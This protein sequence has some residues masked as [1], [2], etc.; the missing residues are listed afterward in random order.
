MHLLSFEPLPGLWHLPTQFEAR[1]SHIG[2]FNPA[3]AGESTPT[4]PIR[5]IAKKTS[6]GIFEPPEVE[7]PNL[8]TRLNLLFSDQGLGEGLLLP[9]EARR[10]S[11]SDACTA[12]QKGPASV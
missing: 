2:P 5:V 6:R 3:C 8:S 11:G 4:T 10:R 12:V 9:V 7:H 1:F